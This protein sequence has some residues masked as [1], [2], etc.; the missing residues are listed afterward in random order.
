M[1]D[2]IQGLL[3]I[4][5]LESCEE[6]YMIINYEATNL[7]TNCIKPRFD[8]PGYKMYMNLENLFT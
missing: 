3:G 2:L 4:Y 5:F 8:Q 7:V 6:M 1:N